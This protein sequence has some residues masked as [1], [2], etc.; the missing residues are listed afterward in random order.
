MPK[1]LG[2]TYPDPGRIGDVPAYGVYA[3]HVRDLELSN[4]HVSYDSPELRPAAWLADID[5]LEV[6]NFVPQVAAGVAAAVI[7]PDV[8]GMVVRDSPTLPGSK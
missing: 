7:A 5:G 1:E 2:T 6:D 8:K 3:R 4:I